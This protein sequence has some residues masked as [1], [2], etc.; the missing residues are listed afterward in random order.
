MNYRHI[1][2]KI[3][4]NA[5]QRQLN[6]EVTYELHHILPRSLFP[7]WKTRQSNLVY[8]TLREHYFVHQLLV[9][10]YPCKSMVF[11]L[12]QMS[13]KYKVKGSRDYERAKLLYKQFAI[14]YWNTPEVRLQSCKKQREVW[15]NPELLKKHSLKMKEV[16]QRKTVSE[17][18]NKNL[19]KARCT[20]VKCIQTGQVFNSL[21]EAAEWCNIKASMKIGECARGLRPVCGKHLET[22]EPLSWE[23]VGHINSKKEKQRKSR[24]KCIELL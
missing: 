13:M 7:N 17:K 14:N 22:K 23:Y 24:S 11:A 9:K 2:C 1:Y 19:R 3:I 21:Q 18:R 4:K 8:L 15:S 12:W 20:P 16:A 5:K 6:P 10:I